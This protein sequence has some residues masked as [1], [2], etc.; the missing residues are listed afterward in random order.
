MDHLS[1]QRKLHAEF[2]DLRLEAL[3]VTHLPN[4]RYLT[5]FTGSAGVVLV[6]PTKPIFITDGRYTEQAHKQ[7]QGARLLISK[8]AALDAVA[9]Q[10]AR[11]KPETVG[12]ESEH[13]TVAQRSRFRKLLPA[14][15]KLRETS[16]VVE[17]LRMIKDAEEID[18]I[19]KAV[20]LGAELFEVVLEAIRPGVRESEVAAELEYAA[21]T[22]GAEGM[23]FETIV[24]AGPRSALPHGVASDKPIPERGFVVLDYGVILAGYCSDQT[25]TVHLGKPS[26]EARKWYGAVL[27]SQ[28]AG[29]DAVKAGVTAGEVDQATRGVL[30]R[31]KL[32]RYFSHSTGH[33]VGLEIHEMPRLGRNQA[34]ELEAGMVVTIEP[35]IYVEGKGGIRIEDMVAV[36]DSGHD[37]LTQL[38]KELVVL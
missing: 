11:F 26:S 29:V 30:R 1:R 32:D 5:G 16:G 6:G 21:R 18:A 27:E 17:R 12:I 7:V 24:A 37:I 20:K 14:K 33:G 2:A 23:S 13:M 25:R 22:R 38:S 35:G 9:Q 10:I 3:L 36:T 34:E 8:G 15:T 28:L 31:A 4:V 19:R